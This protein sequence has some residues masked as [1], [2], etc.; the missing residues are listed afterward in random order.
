[1]PRVWDEAVSPGKCPSHFRS[2]GLCANENI[3]GGRGV[4]CG[5]QPEQQCNDSD[6]LWFLWDDGAAGER[7]TRRAGTKG[8]QRLEVRRCAGGVHV[9][10][11]SHAWLTNARSSSTP[12]NAAPAQ[13]PKRRGMPGHTHVRVGARDG[14]E[15]DDMCSGVYVLAR[16][17]VR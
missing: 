6:H 9:G 16:A 11:A 15:V 5:T 10:V 4:G 12:F 13:A 7:G 14:L 2:Q 17:R 1:M 3:D 8:G